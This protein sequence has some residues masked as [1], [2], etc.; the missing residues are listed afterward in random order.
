MDDSYKLKLLIIVSRHGPDINGGPR[1]PIYKIES[2][3]QEKWLY[4]GTYANLTEKGRIMAVEFGKDVCKQYQEKWIDNAIIKY[5]FEASQYNRTRETALYF[6]KGMVGHDDFII[7]NNNILH[8][9]N[10]PDIKV[11]L[12][13]DKTDKYSKKHFMIGTKYGDYLETYSDKLSKKSYIKNLIN[14][15]ALLKIN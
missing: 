6:A 7:S 11:D 14:F 2:L 12:A 8:P 13:D 9:G 10:H 5:I 1:E 4:Q 3:D 15:S